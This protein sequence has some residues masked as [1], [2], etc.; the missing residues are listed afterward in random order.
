MSNREVSRLAILIG[1]PG[2]VSSKYLQGVN[3]DLTNFG[4]FLLSASGGRWYPN[5]IITL[6]NASLKEVA[7]FIQQA[8]VDYIMV[9]YSGHG[10]TNIFADKRMLSLKDCD[11]ED[12]FLLNR[13]PRQLILIDACRN[14]VAPGISGVPEFGEEPL[15]FD[16]ESGARK[17]FDK[18][19]Q[20]S[21]AG[22]IIIHGTQKGQ[23]SDDSI[24]GGLFTRSLLHVSSKIKADNNFTAA[25]IE[26]VIG[27]VPS[28]LQQ[29]NNY[30]IPSITYQT[31]QLKTAFA[32]GVPRSSVPNIAKRSITNQ[33]LKANWG[34][35][36]LLA[37]ILG[38]I[39]GAF[40]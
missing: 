34:S 30:Q 29:K 37:L 39:G 23:S 35:L 15:H 26:R 10:Y 2:G 3:V 36:A 33:P 20:A 14:Y 18:Y 5:E 21:P 22:R 31:G 17:L 19:I 4:N 8:L 7:Y 16:G 24:F 27:Y 9:Y 6:P 1:S 25:S 13:S 38:G 11:V 12:T 28:V 40:D 32:L